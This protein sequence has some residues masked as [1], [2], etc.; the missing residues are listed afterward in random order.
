M[1]DTTTDTDADPD[2]NIDVDTTESVAQD[3]ADEFG[4]ERGIEFELI[5][6]GLDHDDM[7]S[8]IRSLKNRLD[9]ENPPESAHLSIYGGEGWEV[10]YFVHDEMDMKPQTDMVGHLAQHIDEIARYLGTSPMAAAALGAKM[11]NK[12]RDD[13][14]E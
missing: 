10:A 12:R 7:A 4:D 5:E 9:P 11:A 1:T 14:D 3:D 8:A 13:E 6:D 2:S